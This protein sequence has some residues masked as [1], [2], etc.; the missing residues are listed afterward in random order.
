MTSE[1]APPPSAKKSEHGQALPFNIRHLRFVMAAAE[2]LSLNAAAQSLNLDRTTV[3]RAIRDFEERLGT[4]IFERGAFGVRL[5]DAGG[6]LVEELVPAFAQIENAILFASAAGRAEKGKVRIGIISTLAGGFLR[7][8]VESYECAYPGV[9][10]TIC[11]GGRREH[12]HAVRTRKLDIAFLTAVDDPNGCDVSELWQERVYVAM[13]ESHNLASQQNLD[14][15]DLRDELVLIARR[16]PGPDVRDYVVRRCAGRNAYPAIEFIEAV[17]ETLM[18]IVAIGRHITLVTEAWRE[19]AIPGL[20]LVPLVEDDDIVQ[21]S[22]VWSPTNDNPSLRR[23]ISFA[24][25]M[26]QKRSPS[27]GTTQRQN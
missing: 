12:L 20:T 8:L 11:D 2:H 27:Q 24:R 4:G 21:F 16:A 23:F 14:W 25:A 13:S 15:P 22:A 10:L 1:R 3:S 9:R 7:D 26:A 5:T 17:Q 6:R 19:M 18:H